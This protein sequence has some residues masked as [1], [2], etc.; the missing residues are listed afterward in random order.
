MV[1]VP[2]RPR[3]AASLDVVD[4]LRADCLRQRAPEGVVVHGPEFGLAARVV[5][6]GCGQTDSEFD[7][8][9]VPGGGRGANGW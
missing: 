1:R 6:V 5:L 3:D 7:G 9:V 8:G 4:V 2:R